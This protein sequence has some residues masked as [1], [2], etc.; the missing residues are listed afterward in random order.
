MPAEQLGEVGGRSTA[1][2]DFLFVPFV[3]LSEKQQLL[4][5][6]TG[7]LT[8]RAMDARALAVAPP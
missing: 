1:P 3:L 4:R 2:L 6:L 7:W 8:D 5:V